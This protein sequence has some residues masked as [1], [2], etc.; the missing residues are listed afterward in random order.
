[1]AP[2]RQRGQT[3]RKMA[4]SDSI[5]QLLSV[6][7]FS[8]A[9][10][11]GFAAERVYHEIR[12]GEKNAFGQTRS[13]DRGQFR[14]DCPAGNLTDSPRPRT[15]TCEQTPGCGVAGIR[16]APSGSTRRLARER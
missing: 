1:M 15:D 4:A 11:I 7:V 5:G 16:R 8:R 6:Y 2:V 14:F 3:P 10:P 9:K 12:K 13:P